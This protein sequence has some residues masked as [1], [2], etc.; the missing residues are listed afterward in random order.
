MKQLII[1]VSYV[2]NNE[3]YQTIVFTCS[4]SMNFSKYC[5]NNASVN[6]PSKVVKVIVRETFT[7]WFENNFFVISSFQSEFL[8][9]YNRK[10]R[11]ASASSNIFFTGTES[12]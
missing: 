10:Y 12:F 2:E 5:S 7:K 1:F 4:L 3:N 9:F 6:Y 8:V 11:A